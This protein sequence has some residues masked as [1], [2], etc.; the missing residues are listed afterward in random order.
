M[1]T[2]TNEQIARTAPSVFATEPWHKVSGKY[3]FIPTIQIVEA[4]RN[5]GFMPV[6]VSQ[7]KTR[8]VGKADFTK[9][10][11]RFRREQDMIARPSIVNGN[12]HH[13]YA[14]GDQPEIPEIVLV[15]SHDASSGYQLSAGIYRQVCSNGLMVK[16]ANFEDI[17]VRHVGDI[18]SAVIEGSCRI[19]EE[20]PRVMGAIDG[21]KSVKLDANQA[22]A[23]ANA[24]LALRYSGDDNGN[25]QAPIQ[26]AQLLQARRTDDAA[27]TLWNVFNVV[28]ENFVKGG[29]RAT[30]ATGKRYRAKG[31]TSVTEDVRLNRAL[32]M[33]TEQMGK[34]LNN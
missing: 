22:L 26:A 19:I 1:Q 17:T 18:K 12:A 13:F 27:P 32:W 15:N 28:Q 9:H 6:K 30:G 16:S 14:E 7:S 23:Y 34:L 8:I 31:I 33:L 25:I 4:L 5:E 2:L 20:M 29:L 21:F 10:M 24:A 11:L 3:A